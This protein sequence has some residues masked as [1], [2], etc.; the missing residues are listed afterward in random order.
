MIDI[1]IPV[2]GQLHLADVVCVSIQDALDLLSHPLRL[3]A[4]LRC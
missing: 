4:T 1:S 3:T 2:F